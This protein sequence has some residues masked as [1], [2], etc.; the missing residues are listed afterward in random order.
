MKWARHS[1]RSTHLLPEVEALVPVIGPRL[2][3]AAVVAVEACRAFW[4]RQRP[5]GVGSPGRRGERCEA[6][7][8]PLK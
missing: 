2:P 1:A 5:R 6:V 3:P 4:T 8:A 7:V